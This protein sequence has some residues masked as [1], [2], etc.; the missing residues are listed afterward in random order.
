MYGANMQSYKAVI[1]YND[2]RQRL[3]VTAMRKKVTLILVNALCVLSTAGPA[4]SRDCY[5]RWDSDRG[6]K[7]DEAVRL[8][9]QRKFHEAIPIF[10]SL[11]TEAPQVA[12]YPCSEA[13]CL[14]EEGR[15][16]ES[17]DLLVSLVTRYPGS[18]VSLSGL[19]V[20]S[21]SLLASKLRT[22]TESYDSSA[23]QS[24]DSL[25]KEA[26]ALC[27][28]LPGNLSIWVRGSSDCA[29]SYTRYVGP[30]GAS[31][32]VQT[33]R[34]LKPRELSARLQRVLSYKDPQD[35]AK[36]LKALTPQEV[37]LRSNEPYPKEYRY[38][39]A[40]HSNRR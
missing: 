35:R 30:H 6:R 17:F 36:M 1:G 24:G 13:I 26:I 31:W 11:S 22:A 27:D 12:L 20:V 38:W 39:L 16:E 23:A 37:S 9:K 8:Q 3:E 34:I 7:F 21:R 14:Y 2:T 25:L 15:V 29:A 32:V 28:R 5:D 10:K 19:E 40:P 18:E 4:M 33:D